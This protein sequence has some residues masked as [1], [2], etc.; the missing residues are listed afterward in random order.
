MALQAQES[1]WRRWQELGRLPYLL[2]VSV[3]WDST[4]WSPSFSIW[5]LP[6]PDFE[7]LCRRAREVMASLPPHSLGSRMVLLDNWNE[8]GEG[9]YI[10]PHRQYGFGY[11][12]AVRAAFTDAPA[13]HTDLIPQ[14]VGLGPY[15]RRYREYAERLQQCARRVMAS[16]GVEPKLVAWW[17]FDEP[18]GTPWAWDYTGHGQGGLVKNASAYPA[19]GARP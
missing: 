15:E 13:A 2:T 5:R 10:A 14:D 17:T 18:A 1:Y 9:H 6:P 11:L 7:A 4:P 19:C 3:G 16:P 12:D 8:F